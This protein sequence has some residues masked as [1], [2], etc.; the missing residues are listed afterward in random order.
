ML[1]RAVAI[2]TGFSILISFPIALIQPADS[3]RILLDSPLP[4]AGPSLP[5]QEQGISGQV[6]YLTRDPNSLTGNRKGKE[7]RFMTAVWIFSGK[8]KA[9][10]SDSSAISGR[11][12]ATRIPLSEA[13][14]YPNL[15]GAI[16]SDRDGRFKVGLK[17]GDYTLMA[18]YATDLYP[19]TFSTDGLYSSIQ[20]IS[21]QVVDTKLI[22]NENL[23]IE[24]M[25]GP[26]TI[27]GETLPDESQGIRGYVMAYRKNYI[28]PMSF[29]RK[30]M[31]P[32]D[33]LQTKVWI[34]SGHVTPIHF[35]VKSAQRYPNLVGWVMSGENGRFSVGLKPGNYS[36]FA[37]YDQKLHRE[38][39][40]PWLNSDGWIR[41][42]WIKVETNNILDGAFVGSANAISF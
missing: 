8:I 21:N 42:S 35:S 14:Q 5:Q 9:P 20:V 33:P 38:P 11:E 3:S 18:Q 25:P 22:N 37:E 7:R 36:I 19:N 12:L 17:P 13:R 26:I 40:R 15:I 6:I 28:S 34:F 27:F 39:F 30:Y 10:I 23:L 29:L 31:S 32:P 41:D 16:F 2:T 1:R 4:L 24:S